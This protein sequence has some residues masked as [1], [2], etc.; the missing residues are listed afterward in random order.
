MS[1]LPLGAVPLAWSNVVKPSQTNPLFGPRTLARLDCT[2]SQNQTTKL[3]EIRTTIEPTS[4]TV[5]SPEIGE[6]TSPAT[7]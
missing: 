4:P 1:F 7:L 5:D 3:Q 2:H 6:I